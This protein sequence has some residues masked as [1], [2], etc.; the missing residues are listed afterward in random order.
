MWS[1]WFKVDDAGVDVENN[2]IYFS[3]NH[4]TDFSVQPTAIEDLSPQELADV[5]FSP[6]NTN[7]AHSPVSISPQG[8]G[9]SMSMTEFV[10]PG[11]NGLDF[12]LRRIYDSATARGDAMGLN[13]N[14][15]ECC[16]H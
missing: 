2:R 9:V 14:V 6:F 12:E 8:G 10:F 4:F 11:K 16:R 13:I 15:G 5:E 1:R 7:T 3:T